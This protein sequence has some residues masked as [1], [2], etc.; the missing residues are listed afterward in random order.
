M[1][2]ITMDTIPT[3]RILVFVLILLALGIRIPLLQ[4]RYFDPDEFQHLHGAYSI[5]QGMVPYKDYYEHHTPW[6]HYILRWLFPIWGTS[7]TTIF[8][9]RALMLVFTVGILYLTYRLGKQ[10][11][12]KNVGL[13]STLL[14]AY[15]LIFLEKTLEI[16]P[17]LP[18]V[19]CWLAG[20]IA[21]IHGIRNDQPRWYLLSG[22]AL[23]GAVMFT[24]KALFGIAGVFVAMAWMHIDHRFTLPWRRQGK[25]TLLFIAG[26]AVPIVLTMLFFLV[27]GG[28]TAF[29]DYNFIMNSQWKTKFWPYN[30][31]RRFI[32]QNPFLSVLGLGGWLL[33]VLSLLRWENIRRGMVVPTAATVTLLIGLYVMPVPYRQYYQ[34][35]LPLWAI[36][37]AHLLWQITKIPSIGQLLE[38]WKNTRQRTMILLWGIGMLFIGWGLKASLSYSHPVLRENPAH[39]PWMWGWL[40]LLL[41]A[42]WL[43][44]GWMRSLAFAGL[45]AVGYLSTPLRGL[46]IYFL[47]P[48]LALT[49]LCYWTH[50]RKLALTLLLVGMLAFPFQQMCEQLKSRN[51]GILREIEYILEN[52]SPEDTIL[53]GWRGSGVFR[54]HAYFYFFLHSELLAMLDEKQK[55]EDVVQVLETK[56]PKIIVYDGAVKSLLPVVQKYIQKHY[57]PT[58]VGVLYRRKS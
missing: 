18:E 24:Q 27:Q 43:P 49:A 13:I 55:G 12:G 25:F 40:L 6:L 35:I 26:L 51:D 42:A 19:L 9:A 34:L 1:T 14:L 5:S 53:T 52:T 56:R 7:L 17:D 4:H 30:Y 58:G 16:R 11:Y 21:L 38:R 20:L 3:W 23:G 44:R 32:Q 33:S 54:P 37:A 22:L 47:L 39:Y 10:L 8:A 36:Y 46:S 48:A 15:I 2:K 31:I 28:L 41:P 29:I 45:F 57:E 50:T